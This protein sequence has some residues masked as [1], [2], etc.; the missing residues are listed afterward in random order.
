MKIKSE[1]KLNEVL[2]SFI[3]VPVYWNSDIINK[4]MYYIIDEEEI[5]EEFERKLKEIIRAVNNY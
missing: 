2:D 3:K 5:R 1:K 4:K